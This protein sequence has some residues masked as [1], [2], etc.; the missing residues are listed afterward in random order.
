MAMRFLACFVPPCTITRDWTVYKERTFLDLH[1]WRQE[2]LK[3]RDKHLLR[4]H[5]LCPPMA[6]Q[7]R[8]EEKQKEIK[9]S[10][11]VKLVP[12]LT[13]LRRLSYPWIG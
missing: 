7:N 13:V 12:L 6:E 2:S 8:E 3:S 10:F 11:P 1:F 5:L 9:Q 4:T